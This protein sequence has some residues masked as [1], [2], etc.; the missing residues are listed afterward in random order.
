LL[1]ELSPTPAGFLW[2][3]RRVYRLAYP[4]GR[5]S[6]PF[7]YDAVDR[8]ARD[9]V[10]ILAHCNIEGQRH[11][12][13][14]SAQRPPLSLRL[15]RV[16]PVPETHAGNLWELPAGLV[17]ETEASDLEGVRRAA[18]RELAEELGFRANPNQLQE[19]G[20]SVFPAPGVLAERQ[21]FYCV[22]VNPSERQSPTLDGSSLEE[23][24]SVVLISVKAALEMCRNGELPDSKSELAIRR[25]ADLWAR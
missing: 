21:F 7:T 8:K 9:A 10:V 4:S 3:V 16:S 6:A 23:E 12:F 11:L 13:L 15:E 2:L 19:L 1:D 14:R 25:F 18:V 5:I 24:A 22:E 20:P 17:E